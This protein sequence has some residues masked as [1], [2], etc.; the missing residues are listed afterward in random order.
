MTESSATSSGSYTI[1]ENGHDTITTI[2]TADTLSGA[3]SQT[4]TGTDTYTLTETGTV[5]S[6]AYSESVVGTDTISQQEVGNSI[7]G[8]YTRSV[9][10]GGGYSL[11][12]TGGTMIPGSGTNSYSL[13]ESANVLTGDFSISETGTDRYGLLQ[14]FDNIAQTSGTSAPGH[15]NYSPFGDV[16]VDDKPTIRTQL[17]ES[18]QPYFEPE[19]LEKIIEL[20]QATKE[21]RRAL[22]MIE[23]YGIRVWLVGSIEIYEKSAT[24]DT[25]KLTG[26]AYGVTS[27]GD[28]TKDVADVSISM[29]TKMTMLDIAATIVHEVEH[30]THWWEH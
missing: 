30:A 19:E 20:L 18:T 26:T 25:Y 17:F 3:Y 28:Y 1:S 10:G 6:G 16:F 4:Q 23:K 15:M 14:E 9:S 7:Q 13:T 21:G 24:D 8:T 11:S 5:S 12:E 2:D 29:S 22:A 27:Y